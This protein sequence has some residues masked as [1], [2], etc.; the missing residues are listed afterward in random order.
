MRMTVFQSLL[1][2]DLEP[3]VWYD[4]HR[5]QGTGGRELPDWF[6]RSQTQ[7]LMTLKPM[8]KAGALKGRMKD[9]FPQVMRHEP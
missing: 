4:C 9:G 8:I 7:S 3:G 5:N 1:W 6:H 2:R